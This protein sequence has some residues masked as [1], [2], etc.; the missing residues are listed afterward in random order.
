[1]K[2]KGVLAADYVGIPSHGSLSV[3]VPGAVDGWFALHERWGRLTMGEVLEQP[4]RYA[5]EVFP[6]RLL[7]QQVL[8]LI[9]AVSKVLRL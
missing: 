6:C 9:S 2:Q 1:M 5:N 4:I 3:T 7:S 8:R